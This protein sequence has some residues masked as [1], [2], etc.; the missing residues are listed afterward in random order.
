MT[1]AGADRSFR[2]RGPPPVPRR[3]SLVRESCLTPVTGRRHAPGSAAIRPRNVRR[4]RFA[5]IGDRQPSAIIRHERMAAHR[6]AGTAG[7]C[8]AV[9]PA[10]RASGPRGA[11]AT[12]A[13]DGRAGYGRMRARRSSLVPGLGESRRYVARSWRQIGPGHGWRT[14]ALYS[15]FVL[16]GSTR[17]VGPRQGCAWSEHA[18]PVGWLPR[19]SHL[20]ADAT[21]GVPRSLDT[22]TTGGIRE[23]MTS[24]WRTS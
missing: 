19:P 8:R 3:I 21:G 10:L 7:M 23:R 2:G 22:V 17:A 4:S 24:R 6:I 18:F 12:E 14:R 1:C 13:R 16:R 11:P 5:G 15:G 9:P 20:A